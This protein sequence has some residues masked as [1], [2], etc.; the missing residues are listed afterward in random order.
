MT[1]PTKY[2]NNAVIEA[3]YKLIGAFDENPHEDT[4]DA[5]DQLAEALEPW[6]DQTIAKIRNDHSDL[7]RLVAE[8]M[9]V[10]FFSDRGELAPE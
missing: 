8:V 2:A 4:G 6:A 7:A 10:Q 5:I 1:I 9:V 3:G